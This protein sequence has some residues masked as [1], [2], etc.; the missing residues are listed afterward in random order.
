MR[1]NGIIA[2]ELE[3]FDSNE[4]VQQPQVEVVVDRVDV[5]VQLAYQ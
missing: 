3:A 5:D 2:S 4:L 1:E